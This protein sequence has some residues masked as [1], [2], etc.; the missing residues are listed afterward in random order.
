MM[1]ISKE[2]LTPDYYVTKTTTA[3]A[4]GVL[5]ILQLMLDNNAHY[6]NVTL[7]LQVE[8]S[9]T[10]TEWENPIS[11]PDGMTI[12]DINDDYVAEF[13]P[14]PSGRI[15]MNQLGFFPNR[16]SQDC[17]PS[18]EAYRYLCRKYTT[19][20]E[21]YFPSGK[22]LFSETD[23][24]TDFW[25]EDAGQRYRAGGIFTGVC[26]NVAT[27][28]RYG[29]SAIMPF[30][31]NQR[32]IWNFGLSYDSTTIVGGYMVKNLTVST[33]SGIDGNFRKQFCETGILLTKCC[34]S[35]FDGIYFHYFNGSGLCIQTGWENHFGYLNFR[36]VG[37]L[38]KDRLYSAM[39]VKLH[40]K[41][42]TASAVSACKF[43]YFNFEGIRGNAI[44]CDL[45]SNFVHNEIYDIQAEFS[46]YG[47]GDEPGIKSEII[48]DVGGNYNG[49][50]IIH[51]YLFQ[52]TAGANYNSIIFHS[53]SISDASCGCGRFWW[54]EED[55]TEKQVILRTSG[56]FGTLP[57]KDGKG[58]YG[59]N[60]QCACLSQYCKAGPQVLPIY[61]VP[62]GTNVGGISCIIGTFHGTK[63]P[64]FEVYGINKPCNFYVG[65]AITKEKQNCIV[66]E[67]NK[68]YITEMSQFSIA[69]T[70]IGTNW[71]NANV[72]YMGLVS[73]G[74]RFKIHRNGTNKAYISLYVNVDSADDI[75]G[76]INIQV[77]RQ[78]KDGTS[79]SGPHTIVNKAAVESG[80][81][82]LKTWFEV[83][84]HEMIPNR[85]PCSDIEESLI[86]DGNI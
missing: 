74:G 24:Y 50:D 61:H 71:Q 82:P 25:N 36:G 85:C 27:D 33:G 81:I 13:I 52:G 83:P 1:S 78:Y 58:V 70:S 84:I 29:E 49:D 30:Y 45:A 63:P 47:G 55:G 80:I 5:E 15:V 39:W 54:S 86:I 7:K 21:L 6:D 59:L 35:D 76:N 62:N 18:I 56:I 79:N 72:G 57:N 68:K 64:Y 67:G 3:T 19:I 51:T 16:L 44:Q 22:W 23:I 53:I 20:F 10:R 73:K 69:P 42:S 77:T 11:E 32:Y 48:D 46:G 8:Q 9:D 65:N 4:D 75:T 41:G 28:L 37:A 40:P 17:K 60:V 43:D 34:Y 66:L 26:S 12:L 2:N 38:R 31:E 14:E